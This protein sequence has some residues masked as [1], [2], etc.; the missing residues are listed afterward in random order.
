M[1]FA[2]FKREVYQKI[3]GRI[4]ASLQ[5]R[6]QRG[7][8]HHCND[9]ISRIL[10]PGVLIESQDG[11]E[12]SYFC[13]CRAATANFPCPKCLVHKSNLSNI[14]KTFEPRTSASMQFVLELAS[15]ATSK[16]S[17]ERILQDHGLHDIKVRRQLF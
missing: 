12:A 14:T 3:L 15:Q 8:T 4:F 11:E 6:S 2:H 17:K 16:S 13:A 1:E 10:Y 7:E 9:G 5:P